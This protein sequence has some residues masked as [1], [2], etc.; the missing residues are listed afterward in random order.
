M[1]GVARN[2]SCDLPQCLVVTYILD[3]P[4]GRGR[5][6]PPNAG[7][8]LDTI[9]AGWSA[10]GINTFKSGFQLAI[11]ATNNSLANK[12]GAGQV[13]P[14]VIPGYQKSISGSLHA[15]ARAGQPV[16]KKTCFTAPADVAFGNQPRTDGTLRTQVTDNWDFSLGKKGDLRDDFVLLFRAEAFNVLSRVQFGDPNLN[17]STQQFGVLTTQANS[18]RSF[19]FSLQLNY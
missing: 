18:P 1:S 7:N 17:A 10:S 16:L 12:F 4:F 8:A 14:N 9:V 13:R 5:H 15:S 19:Q 2:L 11:I 6:F 3:L